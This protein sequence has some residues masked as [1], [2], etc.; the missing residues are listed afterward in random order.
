MMIPINSGPTIFLDSW[1]K[2]A[3]PKKLTSQ[4]KFNLYGFSLGLAV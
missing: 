3:P 4:A 2:E 1:K